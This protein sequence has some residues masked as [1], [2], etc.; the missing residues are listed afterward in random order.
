[1]NKNSLLSFEMRNAGGRYFSN[2]RGLKFRKRYIR[3][4]H[5]L[6]LV[7]MSNC[8]ILYKMSYDLSNNLIQFKKTLNKPIK[9]NKI[10]K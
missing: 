9:V 4:Y 2:I 8:L 10:S 3:F 5:R 7:I 1:M 6:V